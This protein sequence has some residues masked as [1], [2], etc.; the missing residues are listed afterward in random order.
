[1]AISSLNFLI[2]TI[3][4]S[5]NSDHLWKSPDQLC[6]AVWLIGGAQS[7]PRPLSCTF[8]TPR[9]T[10]HFR[11]CGIRWMAHTGH[12]LWTRLRLR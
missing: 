11:F 5:K 6:R 1:M 4:H 3:C 7:D 10:C 8:S 2:P 9:F 12:T